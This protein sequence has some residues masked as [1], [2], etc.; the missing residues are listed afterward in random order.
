M[1]NTAGDLQPAG[2]PSLAI[3]DFKNS[4]SEMWLCFRHT[5][6]SL[7]RELKVVHKDEPHDSLQS[8]QKIRL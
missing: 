3:D 7:E 1:Y 2:D 8:V 4:V 6:T 5:S